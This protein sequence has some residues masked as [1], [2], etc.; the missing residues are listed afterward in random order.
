MIQ[1]VL[2]GEMRQFSGGRRTLEIAAGPATVADVLRAASI[3]LG[4]SAALIVNGEQRDADAP[5]ADGDTVE[6]L[7]AI[8]G[9]RA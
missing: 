3:P 2:H 6:V 7:P 8:T 5:V 1:L 9:G 4:E